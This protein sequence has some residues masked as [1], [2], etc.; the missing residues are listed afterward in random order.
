MSNIQLDEAL[1]GRLFTD[2]EVDK[3]TWASFD[4]FYKASVYYQD[5][6]IGVVHSRESHCDAFWIYLALN[7]HEIEEQV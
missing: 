4:G 5:R 2:F 6:F 3:P 1:R 7:T